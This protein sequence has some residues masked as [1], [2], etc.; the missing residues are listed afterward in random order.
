M[1]T[2]YERKLFLVQDCLDRA[3]DDDNQQ[4][5]YDQLQ[6]AIELLQQAQELVIPMTEFVWSGTAWTELVIPL[7]EIVD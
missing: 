5:S 3:S 6:R 4:Y 7:A 2:P 1:L